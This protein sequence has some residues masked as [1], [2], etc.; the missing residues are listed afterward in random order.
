MEQ[1]LRIRPRTRWSD[2]FSHLVWSSLGVELTELSEIAAV[3]YFKPF[4]L[5]CSPMTLPKGKL[6]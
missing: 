6:A 2:T 1:G 3:R 4:F 5:G